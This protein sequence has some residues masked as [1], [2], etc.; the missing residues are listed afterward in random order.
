[1]NKGLDDLK[2][3]NL[4]IIKLILKQILKQIYLSCFD[5]DK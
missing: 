3:I 5:I 2:L 1:M 4:I